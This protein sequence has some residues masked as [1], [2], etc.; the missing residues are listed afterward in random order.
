MSFNTTHWKNVLTNKVVFLT[1]AAG[2][3]A[4]YIARACYTHGA[5]LVLGDLRVD[6]LEEVKHEIL[7]LNNGEE[8]R[9]LLVKL[10]VT[11]ETSIERAVQI[12]L[13]KWKTIDVLLNTS[14]LF[15]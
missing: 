10:D 1:G 13:D 5:C 15:H 8:D 14:V 4:R 11:D 2:G 6:A 3:V 12:T 9:I 7:T